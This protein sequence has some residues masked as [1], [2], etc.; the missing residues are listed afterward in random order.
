MTKQIRCFQYQ[1]DLLKHLLG[2]RP[3][4]RFVDV[5]DDD[6]WLVSF[7]KSGSTWMR[8]LIGN[9]IEDD[10]VD[11]SSIERVIPDIYANSLLNLCRRPSQRIIKSHEAYDVRYKKVIYIVRDPRDVVISYWKHQQKMRIIP[12]DYPLELFG[13]EFLHRNLPYG[14]WYGNVGSWLGARK[15][16]KDFMIIKYEDLLDDTVGTLKSILNGID[17]FPPLRKDVSKAVELS[18]FNRMKKLEKQQFPKWKP[19]KKSIK[20]IN[21]MRSGS[22]GQW[23]TTL[24]PDLASSIWQQWGHLMR[25]FGYVE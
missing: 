17:G 18:D 7:P 16:T 4:C 10:P 8:F 6:I 20:E 3:A 24:S 25:E 22:S 13:K 12:L 11:F 14:T 21:F 15:A 19:M 5:R 2:R 23:R 9:L 1:M